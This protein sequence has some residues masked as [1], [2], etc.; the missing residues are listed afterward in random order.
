MANKPI[1][2]EVTGVNCFQSKIKEITL[3]MPVF[4]PENGVCCIY[5]SA[6][7]RRSYHGRNTINPDQTASREQSDLGRYS[8]P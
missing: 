6:L 7:L 3:N 1:S 2:F 8:S 5:S 4:C